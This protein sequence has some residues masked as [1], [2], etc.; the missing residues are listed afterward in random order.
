MTNWY[1]SSLSRSSVRGASLFRC[2]AEA[3]DVL[4]FSR[5]SNNGSKIGIKK[6]VASLSSPSLLE[7]DNIEK[8]KRKSTQVSSVE[9]NKRNPKQISFVEE[10]QRN[11]TQVSSIEENQQKI[12]KI[13]DCE[14]P[15]HDQVEVE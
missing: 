4:S 7:M 11:S 14:D 6:N 10:N 8:S 5:W 3:V 12:T 13:L 2:Q 1:F 9:E 15:F